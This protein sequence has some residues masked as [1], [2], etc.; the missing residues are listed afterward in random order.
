MAEKF[1]PAD[2]RLYFT[3][4]FLKNHMFVGENAKKQAE[5][6]FQAR[7]FEEDDIELPIN[8]L[9]CL[10]KK[11]L[12]RLAGEIHGNQEE[13]DRNPGKTFTTDHAYTWWTRGGTQAK[14]KQRARPHTGRFK[15]NVHRV[16]TLY[17]LGHFAG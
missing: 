15:Y 3:K 11:E 4:K 1:N 10:T 16:K 8:S 7:D 6:R 14:D 12:I 2:A 17:V 9:L 13:Y 5:Q